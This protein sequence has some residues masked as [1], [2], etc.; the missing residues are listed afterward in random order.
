MLWR[1]EVVAARTYLQQIITDWEDGIRTIAIKNINK[2]VRLRE[3]LLVRAGH[4]P[5]YL[6]R[7]KKR[8]W[9]AHS[10]Q[11]TANSQQPYR[12]IQ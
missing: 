7:L 8:E 2:L 9:V 3:Y 5:N 10:P 6:E 1:A 4:I 11:P 12:E